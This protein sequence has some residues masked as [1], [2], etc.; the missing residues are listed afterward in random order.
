[1]WISINYKHK[2]QKNIVDSFAEY[3]NELGVTRVHIINHDK[4]NIDAVGWKPSPPRPQ[5]PE[6]AYAY[7]SLGPLG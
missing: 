6:E 1:M 3:L 4:K 2:V 5:S 7:S